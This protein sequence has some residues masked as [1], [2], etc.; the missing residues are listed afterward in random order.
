LALAEKCLELLFVPALLFILFVFA[1]HRFRQ[2]MQIGAIFIVSVV[3]LRLFRLR[4]GDE[5]LLANEAYFLIAIAA[6]YGLVWLVTRYLG[7]RPGS[8]TRRN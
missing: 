3:V 2:V 6:I 1:R 4:S 7:P 8:T 5:P